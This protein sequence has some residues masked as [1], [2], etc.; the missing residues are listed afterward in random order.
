YGVETGIIDESTR[1]NPKTHYGKS[2]KA[3]EDSIQK[4]ETDEFK[5]AIVRPPMIYGKGCPGNY[6][7]LRKLALR[8]PIFPDVDNRRSMIYIDNL[9]EFLRLLTLNTERGFYCP[10]NEEYMNTALLIKKISKVNNKKVILINLFTS[11]L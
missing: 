9:S 6:Q 2:K 3:A 1:L 10:Q 5:V 8:T 7:R 4:L 11:I